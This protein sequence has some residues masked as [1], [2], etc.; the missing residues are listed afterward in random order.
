MPLT[1]NLVFPPNN[2]AGLSGSRVWLTEVSPGLRRYPE[3]R[4]ETPSSCLCETAPLDKG[5]IAQFALQEE[6]VGVIDL[7]CLWL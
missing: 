2:K 6:I 5:E 7:F 4:S 3:S 1:T